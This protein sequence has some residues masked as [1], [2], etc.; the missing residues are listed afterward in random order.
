M[1]QRGF[2]LVIVLFFSLLLSSTIA[3]FLA[4][5]FPIGE[6]AESGLVSTFSAWRTRKTIRGLAD[7]RS[8]VPSSNCLILRVISPARSFGIGID[9][10]YC[11]ICQPLVVETRTPVPRQVP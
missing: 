4:R 11:E 1:R 2:V 8:F 5:L 7:D 6:S 10:L 9:R 3:S